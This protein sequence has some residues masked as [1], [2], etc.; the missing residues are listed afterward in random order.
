MDQV[1]RSQLL[2]S[3]L[4]ELHREVLG[5]VDETVVECPVI[6]G[7]EC[8]SVGYVIDASRRLYRKDMRCV[9]EAELYSCHSAAI[10]VGEKY[11]L[12]KPRLTRESADKLDYAAARDCQAMEFAF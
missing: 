8:N 4:V 3:F 10:I 2:N 6:G 12:A 9:H 7:R 1:F 5:Q 11:L